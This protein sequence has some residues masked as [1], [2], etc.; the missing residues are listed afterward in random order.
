MKK[1]DYVIC[2]KCGNKIYKGEEVEIELVEDAPT[3]YHCS[4]CFNIRDI[5]K[6]C[7]IIGYWKDEVNNK[8]KEI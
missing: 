1:K 7:D 3:L 8:E 2:C 6:N 5:I 4:E